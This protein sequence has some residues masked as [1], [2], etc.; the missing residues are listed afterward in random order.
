M[1]VY[2]LPCESFAMLACQ[3]SNSVNRDVFHFVLSEFN[4]QLTNWP[5]LL[6]TVEVIFRHVHVLVVFV[7]VCVC[8]TAA[9][10]MCVCK[11]TVEQGCWLRQVF[12]HRPPS[13]FGQ[14]APQTQTGLAMAC[15]RLCECVCVCVCVCVHARH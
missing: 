1:C 15:V 2:I 7:C 11:Q 3:H 9:V 14:S 5:V 13:L 10:Y 8:V 4:K 12:L 6:V